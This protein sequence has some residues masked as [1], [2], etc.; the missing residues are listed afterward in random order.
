MKIEIVLSEAVQE[1]IVERVAERLL[2]HLLKEVAIPASKEPSATTGAVP[3]RL[4]WLADYR[5][6]F[7]H[8][9]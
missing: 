8:A 2:S 3:E 6:R 1:E 9:D 5:R 7:A 4:G